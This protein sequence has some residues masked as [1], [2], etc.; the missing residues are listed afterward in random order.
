MTLRMFFVSVALALALAAAVFAVLRSDERGASA[1][2]S[3]P[4]LDFAIAIDT[5]QD[6]LNDCGTGAPSTVG[7]GAPDLVTADV[8]NTS[9]S[10][11][12][13]SEITVNV[14]LM[15]NGGV[16]YGTSASHV[17]YDGLTPV[18][19]GSSVWTCHL[20]DA[21]AS[22]PD[23]ENAGSAIGISPPCNIA[24]TNVGLMNRFTFECTA[25]GSL[26]LGHSLGETEL[27]DG[28]LASHR[29]VG[30]DA[31][32]IDCDGPPPTATPTNTPSTPTPTRTPNSDL[33]FAIGIDTNQDGIN[34]CG[35]GVPSAVG[36]GAP[37]FVGVD[38]T[39]TSCSDQNDSE[40]TVNVYL[41]DN[42]G[43]PYG[44]E[45][46][47]V[48]Y[49]G[50]WS[51]SLAG[52]VW[53]CRVFDAFVDGPGFEGASSSIGF[54]PPCSV[55][56]TNLGLMNTF[57]F[58]CAASG[59]IHLGHSQGETYLT[60]DEL[61]EQQEVGPDALDI[62]CDGPTATPTRTPFSV[63]TSTATPTPLSP[64]FAIGVDTDQDGINDC[65]TGVPFVVGN[66]A[67]D[68]IP[69]N[70]SNTVCTAGSGST[71][72]VNVYL[73]SHGGFPYKGIAAHV[74]YAGVTSIARGQSLWNCHIYDATAF[75][76]DFEN[77]GSIVGVE[78]PCDVGQ[79][80]LGLMAR[81]SFSC[82]QDGTLMLG[83][84]DGETLL[85]DEFTFLH[86]EAGPD[87]LEIQCNA[88]PTPTALSAPGDTD[89][90]GCT[91]A[92][93]N[94]PSEMSG[95]RRRYLNEWDYFNPTHD[96]QNRV[97]DILAVVDQYYIDLGVPGYTAA[98]DRSLI[99]PNA[100]N[101]GPPNGLQRIDDILNIV[102]Q[103]GH[104]CA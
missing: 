60:D 69:V 104:D 27:T 66:G 92:Q 101:L 96:G 30:P 55:S 12:N 38:V 45:A 83:H 9:C 74:Y 24:Q 94:G 1:H 79:S 58:R 2:S 35:S 22:G 34:D 11:Q 47:L 26:H 98:T 21:T 16:A 62:D 44:A 43:I 48:Y 86:R 81:F 99:G 14:Y 64:S 51:A 57:T 36:D 5:D 72:A 20:F 3:H 54:V 50:V 84:S 61:V 7:D 71:L 29:E 89:G 49:S 77:V 52:S 56:Q 13:S 88:T 19:P 53:A 4:G 46:A 33:N 59:T 91:D 15:N 39:N 67:P 75:G 8:T 23:F 100:W 76:P 102:K 82:T 78:S 90:D 32:D 40:M 85:A 97:D 25:D 18:M 17:Y 70:V 42:G 10:D 63:N 95:G 41:M 37:D 31:L 87:V 73:M 80:S 65:G 68:S 6:G 93:E 28:A 103:Y